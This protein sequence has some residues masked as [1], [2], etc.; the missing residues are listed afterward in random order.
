ML[1]LILL[2]ERLATCSSLEA[3]DFITVP[4]TTWYFKMSANLK[5]CVLLD[6]SANVAAGSFS[7]AWLVGAN[8]V[9]V[10]KTK[11]TKN[12]LIHFNDFITPTVLSRIKI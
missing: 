3:A 12:E 5:A 1:N 11:S 10:P 4:G 2:P 6:R 9:K 8:T 7:N